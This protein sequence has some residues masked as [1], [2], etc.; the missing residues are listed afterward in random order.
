M[1]DLRQAAE[2]VLEVFESMNHEDAVFKGEFDSEVEALRQALSQPEKSQTA[3]YAKKIEQLI[4]ERDELRQ[5][6]ENHKLAEAFAEDFPNTWGKKKYTEP[7]KPKW[8]GLSDEE[9][10]EMA[11]D[12]EEGY[13]FLYR[14]FATAIEAKLKELNT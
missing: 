3:A 8:V 13:V 5:S 1:T 10:Q 14:G 4:K 2:M 7:L 11:N 6:F 12:F 9:I